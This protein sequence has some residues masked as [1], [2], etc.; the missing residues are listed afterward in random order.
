[1]REEFVRPWDLEPVYLRKPDV[2]INWSTRQG[3]S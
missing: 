3:G 1:M 2:D